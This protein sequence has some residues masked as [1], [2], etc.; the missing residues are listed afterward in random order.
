MLVNFS[1]RHFN[2][3]QF[4]A[5]LLRKLAAPGR[6]SAVLSASARSAVLGGARAAVASSQSRAVEFGAGRACAIIASTRSATIE[7]S[8]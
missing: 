4:G 8:A 5:F 7:V 3:R 1:L 6:R 2:L